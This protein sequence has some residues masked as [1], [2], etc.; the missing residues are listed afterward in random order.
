MFRGNHPT[1]VDE[2][3]RLKLPA[4]FKR[5]ID[6]QYGPQFY[7]T[8]KDGRVAE[9]YPLQEWEKIEEKLAK[10]PNFNP[11][12]KKYLDRVNYYGQMAEIDAQGRVLLP[13]ILR[14]SAQVMGDVVVF[15]MQTYLK[16]T[17]HDAFRLDLDQN[18]LTAEDEQSLASFDL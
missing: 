2:K 13:Q 11:A 14:E 10:I 15:G 3:G 8:S 9:I 18:P 7:I 1:R 16:V 6:E 12:K 5:L 4:E 17:N